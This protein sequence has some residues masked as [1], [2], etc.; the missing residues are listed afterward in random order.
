MREI[1]QIDKNL[2]VTATVQGEDL[3]F[4]NVRTEPFQVYGLL[5]GAPEAP[6]R[7]IPEDVA[8]QVSPGV[9]LLHR[10]TAGGR[11]R[12][13]TD[14]RCVAIRAKMPEKVLMPHMPFLGSSGFDLYVTE[15]GQ[16]LYKGSFMPPVDRTDGY[17]SL[18][19][20]EDRRMRDITIHFPLYD[21][22]DSLLIG[23]DPDAAPEPGQ[24]YRLDKPV[25][26]Y[27]S[28]ITQGGCA[29]RPGNGYSNIISRNL[30]IDHINL[31]FS[32]NARGEEAMADYIAGLSMSAFVF[33]Y[34]HNAP[35]P[36][37]LERT[38]EPFFQKIRRAHPELPILLT[39]RTD[40][41]R[42]PRSLEDTLRRRAIVL[43][44]Y[45]NALAQGDRNVYFLD[46]GTVFSMAEALG[47]TA[48]SCTV[49]GCHPNDLGFACMAKAFGD[50]LADALFPKSI[51]C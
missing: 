12:F 11:V 2:A 13:R 51:I 23:L 8:T 18:L 22:V 28:S 45:E 34:D 36:E 16:W 39:T 21:N 24:G 47:I 26:F 31:G 30:D 42:D 49:D 4:Y 6:F 14:S 48:D 46:G 10:R 38:H 9:T 19:R 17:E 5:P 20:F 50:I 1:G 27:G 40:P 3:R 43:K 25:V 44:T 7:R 35:D 41:P 33:D 32:G 15:N 29:S 37:H